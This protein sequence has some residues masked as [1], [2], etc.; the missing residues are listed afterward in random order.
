MN[1]V[2]ITGGAG[3]IGSHVAKELL[4]RGVEVIIYDSFSMKGR[5]DDE[6]YKFYVQERLKELNGPVIVEGDIRDK[7][8]FQRTLIEHKPSIVA[9]LAAISVADLSNVY[10]E[11]AVSVNIQGTS[12]VLEVIKGVG[13]VKR[14]IFGSSS[15]VYGDFQYFPAD[16]EHPKNPKEIYGASKLS[17]EILTQAFQRKFQVEYTIIR[18]SA[19]YGPTDVNRRVSQIFVENALQGKELVLYTPDSKLDFSYVRDVARGYVLAC[20]A[21]EAK[22][23]IF[24]ITKGEGRSLREF[25]GIL[26]AMIPNAKI[27]EQPTQDFRPRRGAMDISKARKLLGYEPR[28]SLE[29]GLKEYVEYVSTVLPVFQE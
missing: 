12:N 19:V 5:V 25:A 29:E 20:F 9:H 1:K 15:M 26:K 22:N 24:N 10:I 27:V 17:G 18:P 8:H 11:E 23:E 14:F 6:K 21:D 16:E 4:S 2:L 3:F 28:Y 7:K 13:S